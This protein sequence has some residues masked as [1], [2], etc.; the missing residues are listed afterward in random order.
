[1]LQLIGGRRK[2]E[3]MEENALKGGIYNDSD[4]TARKEPCDSRCLKSRRRTESWREEG[5]RKDGGVKK[6]GRKLKNIRE[7]NTKWAGGD[8]TE[9]DNCGEG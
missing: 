1:M 2:E 9:R 5:E 3:K 8:E 7:W 4:F 6:K